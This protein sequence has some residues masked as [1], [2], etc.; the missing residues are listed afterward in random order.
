MASISSFDYMMRQRAEKRQKRR[1]EKE[2]QEFMD[3]YQAAQPEPT[4]AMPA[5]P[6]GEAGF[7]VSGAAPGTVASALTPSPN[8]PAFM[9]NF[10]QFW[11]PQRQLGSQPS[12]TDPRWYFLGEGAFPSPIQYPQPSGQAAPMSGFGTGSMPPSM[13]ISQPL[14]GGTFGANPQGPIGGGMLS[15]FRRNMAPRAMGGMLSRG[16]FG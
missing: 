10:Q 3:R 16:Y 6:I 8:L 14:T 5:A 1:R 11:Q 15:M 9:P 2:W 13:G 4:S 7:P 12:F